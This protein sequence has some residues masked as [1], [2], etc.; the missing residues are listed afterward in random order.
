MLWLPSTLAFFSFFFLSQLTSSLGGGSAR[1]LDCFVK[2]GERSFER[3]VK[4][5]LSLRQ[6]P[7]GAGRAQRRG[8]Q[9]QLTAAARQALHGNTSQTRAPLW[10]L[11][12]ACCVTGTRQEE[13][14]EEATCALHVASRGTGPDG[15]FSFSLLLLTTSCLLAEAVGSLQRG[16]LSRL[17]RCSSLPPRLFSL[18][19]DPGGQRFEGSM[20]DPVWHGQHMG[21]ARPPAL[22]GTPLTWFLAPGGL[23]RSPCAGVLAMSK[24]GGKFGFLSKAK[25][26][27]V[28]IC[29]QEE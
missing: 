3:G 23:R 24:S 21:S 5:D 14:G 2:S 11:S 13:H 17:G 22:L 9:S 6:V 15:S 26:H 25:G 28:F 7:V 10:F 20:L 8:G 16:L 1:N 18:R 27:V 19:M 4:R 12:R 29:Q